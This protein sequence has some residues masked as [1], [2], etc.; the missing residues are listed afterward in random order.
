VLLFACN[1]K[2]IREVKDIVS[3]SSQLIKATVCFA[4]IILTL[5]HY[6]R[7]LFKND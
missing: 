3:L 1:S 2:I 7:F 4:T 6:N 5:K